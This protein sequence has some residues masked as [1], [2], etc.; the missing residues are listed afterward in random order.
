VVFVALQPRL[1]P[2]AIQWAPITKGHLWQNLAESGFTVHRRILD[3]YIVGGRQP[4]SDG[5]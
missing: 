5:C 1:E 3:A 2:L 4:R